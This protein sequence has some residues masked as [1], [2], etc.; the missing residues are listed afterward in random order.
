[1]AAMNQEIQIRSYEPEDY[2]SLKVVYEKTGWFDEV[3]DAEERL[4]QKIQKLHDSVLVAEVDGEIV[5]SVSL[6]EDIRI[7]FLFRLVAKDGNGEKEIIQALID[8][9]E[10]R[11]K[12]KGYEEVHIFVKEEDADRQMIYSEKGF[13]KGNKYFWFWKKI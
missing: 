8:E 10:K 2:D 6:I 12:E 7:A 13:E 11:L 4:K 9:G 1:M 5:G 3:T